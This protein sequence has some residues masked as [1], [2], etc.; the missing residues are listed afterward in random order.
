MKPAKYPVRRICAL[1][2]EEY[3]CKRYSAQHK[4]SIYTKKESQDKRTSVCDGRPTSFCDVCQKP[5][6]RIVHIT[7]SVDLHSDKLFV[8]PDIPLCSPECERKCRLVAACAVS[9][10]A[11]EIIKNF[12]YPL[13]QERL[14]NAVLSASETAKI[15]E[16]LSNIAV[17]KK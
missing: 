4:T 12:N 14:Q 16:E 1:C 6:L 15:Q 7:N 2:G 9:K 5:T 13:I 17:A 3:E 11:E 10:Q 8:G